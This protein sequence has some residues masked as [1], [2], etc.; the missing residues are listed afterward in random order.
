MTKHILAQIDSYFG[1][2]TRSREDT[3]EGLAEILEHVAMLI[4][5]LNDS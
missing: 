3:K 5:T 2:T 1:D 4:E